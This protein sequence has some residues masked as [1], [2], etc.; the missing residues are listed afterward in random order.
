MQILKIFKNSEVV[1]TNGFSLRWS[2]TAQYIT[3]TFQMMHINLQSCLFPGNHTAINIA[4]LLGKMT[5][6]WCID[7]NPQVIA[8]TTDNAK[9][10]TNAI[11]EESMLTMIPCA[12][13]LVM[14]LTSQFSME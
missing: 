6:K 4:E 2:L 1:R 3:P 10:I 5:D 13:L 8:V 7:I 12:G 9:N 11:T 14:H